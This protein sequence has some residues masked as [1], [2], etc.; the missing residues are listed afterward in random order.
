MMN[1]VLS[2]AKIWLNA[3][4]QRRLETHPILLPCNSTLLFIRTCANKSNNVW[5]TVGHK[6]GKWFPDDFHEWIASRMTKYCCPLKIVIFLLRPLLFILYCFL[7]SY[8]FFV[9]SS[10]IWQNGNHSI[11]DIFR[12]NFVNEQF[13]IL[14][15]I[16]LKFEF[17][18]PIDN[19]LVLVKI[20]AWC[21]IGVQ[22]KADPIHWRIY[23][24]LGG[25]WVKIGVL[26]TKA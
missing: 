10:T 2:Y 9:N 8:S 19:S 4:S 5:L 6:E 16:S 25:R 20:M 26:I 1:C 18:G 11:D 3:L 23:A 12:C 21:R 7:Q 17:K 24:A 13:G 22:I 14:I 15:K